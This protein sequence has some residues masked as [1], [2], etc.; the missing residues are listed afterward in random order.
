MRSAYLLSL[1]LAVTVVVAGEKELRVPSDP[2]A[3]FTILEVGGEYPNRTIV[4]RRIG[5]SG[6]SYSKRLY[7]CDAD[8]VKYLG[9]GDSLAEMAA[10][11]PDPRMGPIIEGSIADYV[12]REACR[13]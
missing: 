7:N 4:T 11:K 3:R 13:R 10:S 9:S 6:T 8:Q 5:S 2:N 12:G 1:L